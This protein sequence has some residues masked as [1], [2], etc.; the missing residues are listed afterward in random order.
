MAETIYEKDLT[1]LLIVDPYN[2]FLSEGGKLYGYCEETIKALNTV[3]N[4]RQVMLA[5][6]AAGIRIF[7]TPHHRWHE[8]DFST[9]EHMPPSQAAAA[10]S[11]VF[12]EGSWGGEF[13]PDFQPKACDIVAQQHWLSSGFASTD[14]DLQLKRHGV[15]KVI[16]IGLRANTCIESTMRHAAELGY[17]VTLVKDAIAAFNFDEVRA[18]VELNAP[19]CE[20]HPF[21]RRAPGK[22]GSTSFWRWRVTKPVLLD[23]RATAIII[24]SWR[25]RI[26]GR[27]RELGRRRGAVDQSSDESRQFRLCR[28]RRCPACN[29]CRSNHDS[30]IPCA[31]IERK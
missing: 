4:M 1:G 13:H 25:N 23:S 30:E 24:T 31:R 19:S 14:L 16:I 9:W 5:A 29:L 18:A 2:D 17:E 8:G 10:R 7:I 15:S 3:D 20:R 11:R 27:H 12:A 6:R 26:S 22:A 21:H 28:G